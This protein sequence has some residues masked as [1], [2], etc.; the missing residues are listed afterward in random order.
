MILYDHY[1]SKTGEDIRT[2]AAG[3]PVQVYRTRAG[4]NVWIGT[5]VRTEPDGPYTHP[6][7]ERPPQM[8]ATYAY[9]AQDRTDPIPNPSR[10]TCYK[11]GTIQSECGSWQSALGFFEEHS[12]EVTS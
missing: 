10:W 1:R 9:P 11:D 12:R 3:K 8:Q 5:I 6:Y 4:V 7:T 2:A